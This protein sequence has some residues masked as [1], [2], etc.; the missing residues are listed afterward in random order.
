VEFR[1]L[2]L[3]DSSWQITG[4]FDVILCRNVLM[5]LEGRHRVAALERMASLLA[6]DGLLM[7]DPAEHLGEARHLFVGGA[8]GVYSGRHE[9]SHAARHHPAPS[10][11]KP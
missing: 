1:I 9:F 11:L 6:S 2:N 4:P 3:A 8:D 7:L 10:E 5:Y